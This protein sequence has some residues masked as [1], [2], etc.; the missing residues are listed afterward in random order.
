MNITL[1]GSTR[2]KDV[3]DK[4][5]AE[6]SLRGHTVYSCALWGHSGDTLTPNNKLMLDAVH[7]S[8]IVNS[9]AILVLNAEDYVGES[10]RREIY[11]AHAM[12]KSI[13]FLE[14]TSD[15]DLQAYGDPTDLFED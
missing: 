1:C 5:N 8:K 14:H 15:P 3:F 13:F 2:F 7:F 12:G 4:A 11:F 9:D 6:L 10:T